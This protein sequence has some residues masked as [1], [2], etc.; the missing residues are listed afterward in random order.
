MLNPCDTVANQNQ[1]SR[2][3]VSANNLGRTWPRLM[4][5][6]DITSTAA[7]NGVLPTNDTPSRPASRTIERYADA[8]KNPVINGIWDQS[9]CEALPSSLEAISGTN[10]IS[11]HLHNGSAS[12][13]TILPITEAHNRLRLTRSK[14]TAAELYNCRIVPPPWWKYVD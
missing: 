7:P 9:H 10:M 2:M 6:A 4:I 11:M 3:W 13:N 8:F 14:V 12:F 5:M 1:N